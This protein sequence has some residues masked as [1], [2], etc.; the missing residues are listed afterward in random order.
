MSYV[1]ASTAYI[2]GICRP[3]SVRIGKNCTLDA[4]HCP[5][6][7]AY[8]RPPV[9]FFPIRTDLGRQ[10]TYTYMSSKQSRNT[11]K[12][13]PLIRKLSYIYTWKSKNRSKYALFYK[14]SPVQEVGKLTRN[15]TFSASRSPIFVR[16]S[17]D[18]MRSCQI[19]LRSDWEWVCLCD[20]N[21]TISVGGISASFGKS[22]LKHAKYFRIIPSNQKLVQALT[23]TPRAIART[24]TSRCLATSKAKNCGLSHFSENLCRHQLAPVLPADMSIHAQLSIMVKLRS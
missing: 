1:I 17:L 22:S 15:Q 20:N 23:R 19:R 24:N 4:E 18:A 8:S 5:R 13:K 6:P 2:N 3:R 7:R 16:P 9:Q 10:I 11:L 21:V 14:K 12:I